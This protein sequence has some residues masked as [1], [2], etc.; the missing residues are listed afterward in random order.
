V[1]QMFSF[2]GIIIG[3]MVDSDKFISS[4]RLGLPQPSGTRW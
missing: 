1:R 2:R 4:E 3:V